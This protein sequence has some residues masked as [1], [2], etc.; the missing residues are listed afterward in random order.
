VPIPKR[1]KPPRGWITVR[2][3]GCHPT[4][5]IVWEASDHKGNQ[6]LA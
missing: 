3:L 5:R 1:I 4:K 6:D 2:S